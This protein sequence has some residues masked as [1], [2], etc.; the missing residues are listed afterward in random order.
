MRTASTTSAKNGLF[1]T[2]LNLL[3]FL[4]VMQSCASFKKNVTNTNPL[5]KQNINQLNGI[6][7]IIDM[8]TDSVYKVL[9][10]QSWMHDNFLT[11]IDRRLIKDTLQIDSLKHYKFE[12]KVINSKKI[13]IHYYENNIVIRE[14]ILSAK[15]KEDGYLYVKNKNFGLV[16]V[17]PILGYLD[18]KRTRMTL[19]SNG[20]IL[21]DIAQRDIAAIVLVFFFKINTYQNR[22]IYQRHIPTYSTQQKTPLP[23][24]N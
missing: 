14:R 22:K 9:N 13:K 12:L 2:I 15:L 7:D 16:G 17:P 10:K 18:L 1:L 3:L 19:D 24:K 6:Y 23:V 11:E 8:H 5:T 20:N 21:F 4:F